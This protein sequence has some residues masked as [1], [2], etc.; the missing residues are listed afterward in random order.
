M[1]DYDLNNSHWAEDIDPEDEQIKEST[2]DL[3]SIKTEDELFDE[4]IE[5]YIEDI[6]IIS[7]NQEENVME[8]PRMRRISRIY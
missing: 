1:E 3:L 2:I 4:Q 8:M 6:N 7:Y 5:D